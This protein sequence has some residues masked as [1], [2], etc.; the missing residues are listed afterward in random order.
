MSNIQ[1][2][3]AIESP[4]VKVCDID[5]PSGLCRGC[6]RTLAEIAGWS[7]LSGT[8]RRRIM[9]ELPARLAANLGSGSQ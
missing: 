9:A 4:C 6:G 5:R 1:N 8:E 7:S 2:R 3:T